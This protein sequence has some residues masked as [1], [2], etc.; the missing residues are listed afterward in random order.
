MNEQTMGNSDLSP[1]MPQVRAALVDAKK[2]S[3]SLLNSV[4]LLEERLSSVVRRSCATDNPMSKQTQ[5]NLVP[6]AEEI[7]SLV[8]SFI[9]INGRIKY[10]VEGLEI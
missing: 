5:E 4:S 10:I 3:E 9:M 2:I 8:N 7:M 6:L 1:V